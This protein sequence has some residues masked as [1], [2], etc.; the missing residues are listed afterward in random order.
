[1]IGKFRKEAIFTILFKHLRRG[2]EENHEYPCDSRC[3]AQ[4]SNRALYEYKYRAYRYAIVLSTFHTLSRKSIV[5][6][7]STVLLSATE[8]VV[9]D[10]R[11]YFSLIWL[12][13]RNADKEYERQEEIHKQCRQRTCNVTLWRVR[14]IIAGMEKQLWFSVYCQLYLSQQYRIL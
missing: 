5:N 12:Q 8:S 13:R 11:P 10:R 3:P 2:T 9:C 7:L 4:D 1:M 14:V 6:W